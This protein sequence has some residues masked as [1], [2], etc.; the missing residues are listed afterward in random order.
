MRKWKENEEDEQMRKRTFSY[1]RVYVYLYK[2]K[3][4]FFPNYLHLKCCRIFCSHFLYINIPTFIYTAKI[5]AYIWIYINIRCI[6]PNIVT[7]LYRSV[8]TH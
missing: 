4:N 3:L 8:Y 5:A 1:T 7:N 6:A 2:R